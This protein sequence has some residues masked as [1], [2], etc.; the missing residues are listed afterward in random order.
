MNNVLSLVHATRSPFDA[1]PGM[2]S[3]PMFS[4]LIVLHEEMIS[5]LRLERLKGV[6]SAD[7]IKSMIEQHETAAAKLRSQLEHLE[8]KFA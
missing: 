6:G 4:E 7:F 3:D 5:Q 8:A 2:L 1:G